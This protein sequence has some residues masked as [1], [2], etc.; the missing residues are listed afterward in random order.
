MKTEIYDRTRYSLFILDIPHLRGNELTDAIKY[1]MLGIYPENIDDRKIQIHKNGRKKWSYMVFILSKDTGSTMLPL[2]TL[3]I[4]YNFAKKTGVSRQASTEQGFF[5]GI[6]SQSPIEQKFA[7][8]N[9]V[10]LDKDWVEFVRVENGAVKSSTVKLRDDSR[11]MEDTKLYFNPENAELDIEPITIYC[12]KAEEDLFKTEETLFKTEDVNALSPALENIRVEFRDLSRELETVNAQKISLF[13]GKSPVVKR[14]RIRA[15]AAAILFIAVFA[16]LFHRQHK[17]K[18]QQY[19]QQ[20]MEQDRIKRISE[21]KRAEVMQLSDL[22]ARYLELTS[23]RVSTP[24]EVAAVISEC[25][26][27]NTR[28]MS[29]VFSNGFFQIEGNT[30]N[31]LALLGNFENHR[32]ISNARLHQVHPDNGRD[33]FNMSGNIRPEIIPVD[34]EL[35]AAAQICILEELIAAENRH[36]ETDEG[37]TPSAFGEAVK[38]ILLGRGCT[39]SH[40]QYLNEENKTVMEFSLRGSGVNFFGALYDICVKRRGWEISMVQIRN[41]YPRNL[42]DIVLHI[43]TVYLP[44]AQHAAQPETSAPYSIS[45]ISQNYFMQTGPA[46]AI[47]PVSVMQ[48]AVAANAERAAWLEYLG[49]VN[50]STGSHLLFI[51]NT[52]TSEIFKL[53]PSGGDMHYRINDTG[54][55]TASIKGRI[56]EIPWRNYGNR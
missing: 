24:F 15:A 38:K 36:I 26:G 11:L 27:A 10:Y 21:Q 7:S 22:R 33:T 48:A 32:L 23:S 34:E 45:G 53:Y 8:G 18:H 44:A 43:K 2:S 5:S 42:L 13:S 56:Y 55:I 16:A 52:R 28:I 1:K 19:L 49:S 54:S 31:S 41:L 4:Q 17:I 40:Y 20:Q 51:K 50:D 25:A 3:L 35:P 29:A 12:N 14:C 47:Q 30:V 9:A 37:L 39:I 6:F 46:Q